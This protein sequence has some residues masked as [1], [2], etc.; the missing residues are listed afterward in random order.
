MME[1]KVDNIN[2]IS[3][4]VKAQKDYF[5]SGQTG[6]YEF[7][8]SMLL[9]L[10][11]AIK[12]NKS[13]IC[14]ALMADM[15]KS[16]YETYM[17]EI[18]MVLDEINFHIKHLKKWMKVKKIKTP[19]AQF[20]SKS[21]ISPEAYG[22]VLIMS[23]WNYPMQ[24]S[25]E[26]LIGAIS[27]GCTAVIK[28]SAFAPN[29]ALALKKIIEESFPSEYITVIAGGREENSQL[30]MEKFDYIFFT[31]G[32]VVG[33]VVMEAAAKHLTPV[34]LEL[35]G[36]SP[37]IVHKDSNIKVAARR[38]LFGKTLN[39]GQTCVAPDY[40]LIHEDK[41]SEF[42][43][44]YKKAISEFFPEGDMSDMNSIINEKHY[45]R[46]VGLMAGE[47]I[48]VGGG[49]DINKRFIEPT[50]IE[51]RDW[52]SPIMQ[53]EIFG[54]VLPMFTYDNMSKVIAYIRSKSKPLALYLFTED[55]SIEKLVLDRLSFGGG[56]INDTIVHL[57]NSNMPFGG[58]GESG[59][60][61]YHGKKSFETFTHYRSILKKGTWLD[62][63][64]RYRPYSKKKEE[65]LKKFLK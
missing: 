25:V 28:P 63:N 65:I 44:E 24:L 34:T 64:L 30:L 15:N 2:N 36:K 56:C 5:L 11:F 35:G 60:G 31:G 53:K 13:L 3:E 42:V 43:E 23:P 48:I 8:K 19:I 40:L 41:K 59:M 20:P 47:K 10:K 50:L 61:S 16:Y 26:P 58:V 18:G 12:S 52:E 38:I 1:N 51:G 49:C 46:L 4:I 54:P 39:A 21:Y 7:R 37:V 14:Q 57:A 22:N 17:T 62:F 33:R 55:K 29:T 9:K 6:N 45:N 32:S 27:A